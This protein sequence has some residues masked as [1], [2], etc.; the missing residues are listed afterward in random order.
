M[1]YL[2]LSRLRKRAKRYY[3]DTSTKLFVELD[4][5]TITVIIIQITS[6]E[7]SSTS[8]ATITYEIIV[9]ATKR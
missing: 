4:P 6:D 7:G 2:Q 5:G 9:V 8:L 1:D 3:V